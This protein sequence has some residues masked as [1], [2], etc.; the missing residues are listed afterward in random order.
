M[1][2]SGAARR[3]DRRIDDAGIPFVQRGRRRHL[4]RR[5][6]A[7]APYNLFAD[8]TDDGQAPRSSEAGG[9]PTT[10][11]GATASDLPQGKPATTLA[12][13]FSGGH[14]TELDAT[15]ATATSTTNTYAAAGDEFPAD[16]VLVLRVEVG[17][18]GYLD[19]AGN[20]VPETQFVGQ[21]P[22]AALPRRPPGPRHVDARTS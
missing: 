15:T 8:L 22:G 11:R 16:T 6:A 18:A 19:P 4:P 21:R 5:L 17:D 2:T 7:R 1:V 9:P 14:T 12:A 10:C 20:P 3:D 13:A